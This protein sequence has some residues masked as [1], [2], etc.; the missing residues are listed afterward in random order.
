ML[1]AFD[2]YLLTKYR[3]G[4]PPNCLNGG[5][6]IYYFSGVTHIRRTGAWSDK[7]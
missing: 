4:T 5:Y 3:Y 1:P 2:I 6:H 7:Y